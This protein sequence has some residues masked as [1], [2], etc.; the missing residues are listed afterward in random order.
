MSVLDR[1]SSP[2]DNHHMRI[3]HA[4]LILLSV[5]TIAVGTYAIGQ[6]LVE[7][8][9][10]PADARQVVDEPPEAPA[11][12]VSAEEYS[13]AYVNNQVAADKAYRGRPVEVAG[14]V[15]AVVKD[16]DG[17]PHVWLKS[18]Y[19]ELTVD[20]AFRDDDGLAFLVPG[21]RIVATCVGDAI[22]N[23]RPALR[24][25]HLRGPACHVPNADG[26]GPVDGVCLTTAACG[27]GSK[28]VYYQGFCPGAADV[29]CCVV[30]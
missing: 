23:D 19:D 16:D 21:Q 20:A 17:R 29:V 30:Q 14:T 9:D 27:D 2:A 6:H 18:A 3:L 8:S 13:W 12:R 26:H 5:S 1:G 15:R 7:K 4:T 24:A 22:E 11:V 25:C 10:E 28:A